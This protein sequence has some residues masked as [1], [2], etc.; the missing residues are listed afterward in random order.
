MAT[1]KELRSQIRKVKFTFL[2]M[3]VVSLSGVLL[4]FLMYGSGQSETYEI[5]AFEIS[6]KTIR[7]PKTIEDTEKTELERVRAEQAVPNSYRFS[8]DI[9]KNRQALLSS[10]FTA[11]GDVQVEA[12]SNPDMPLDKQMKLL[13]K[14]LPGF[15]KEETSLPVTDDQLKQLLVSDPVDLDNLH[16]MLTLVVGRELSRPFKTEQLTMHRYEV[17]RR[18]RQSNTLPRDLLDVALSLGRMAVVETEVVDEE[19][20]AK[21][22]A[23]AR[24]SIEAIR[25][26]QGQ[27]IVREGQLIDRDV[28][29][30]LEL[31]G[32]LNNQ[33]SIKPTLGII[34]YILFISMLIT[35]H[36]GK[37]EREEA[38]KK[39]A[40]LIFCIILLL[41]V[42]LM[43][44]VSYIDH[45]F[46]VLIAFLFPTALVPM[47]V[48]LLINERSAVLAAI[49]TSATA[50]IMLQE[51]LAAIMQMEV[52][53]YI[54]FGG[55]VSIYLLSE[56]GRRSTIL[57]TSLGV[58][59]ANVMFILFYLLMTQTSYTMSELIFY[60]VAAVSSGLVSGALT[61]GL[62]PF[63]ESSFQ[64]LSNMRLVELSNPNHPL[65]KKILV[66]T[67]GTYHHSV[68]VA[69][70]ADAAC[71]AIGANGLL[72]RVGSY[73]H[74]IGKT[75]HP[76]FFIENQ[77]NGRNLHDA[78]TPE[79]SRDMIIAH[80]E[81]GA[82]ILEKH[83][84][85]KELVAIARQHHGTSSVRFFY[86]KA[87]EMNPEVKE[88]EFR[89]PG[90]KPQTK[91]NAVIMIADSVEAA[92]RSMKEPTPEKIAALVN[93][94]VRG[95]LEDD[96]F[97][98]CDLSLREIK[99]VKK[100][101][102]ETLNGIFHHRIEYPD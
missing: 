76:G 6:P 10:I 21:N 22:Q 101:I 43:K 83:H 62:L 14:K 35:L 48:K 1:L 73:Y 24:A 51:G 56:H 45:E 7:S 96:Q 102:C 18:I 59:G 97:D 92:V 25:I 68:M 9:M 78:L 27:V 36:F 67:P 30:Q 63:F 16:E 99:I 100:V 41:A 88:E 87:K 15:E 55:I 39:K 47:L 50:G 11:V 82:R 20:T 69:N 19:Q 37:S 49:I 28:Y 53:L 44:I 77:H 57:Q 40:L 75:I 85:P 58:A 5:S 34:L 3:L 31:S 66:E 61:M 64:L 94:I 98:E 90:P 91:E 95:K 29:H 17:E 65:L 60:A 72:A 74:D 2:L 93:S 42:V 33:S 89:Y 81:D 26:L 52:A 12:N 46:D 84:M 38:F 70:L 71:E 4:F 80:A 79:K 54:L 86:M 32:V 8:E 23:D 13:R